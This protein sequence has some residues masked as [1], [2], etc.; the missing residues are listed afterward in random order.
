MQ[1]QI[2]TIQDDD[3]NFNS[4]LHLACI[5]GHLGVAKVLINAE[6]DVE[7]RYYAFL[8]QNSFMYMYTCL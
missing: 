1:H 8:V 5:N 2:D 4:P 3:I 7:A 6:A